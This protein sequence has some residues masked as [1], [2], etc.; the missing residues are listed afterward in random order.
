MEAPAA[1]QL[2]VDLHFQ[3]ITANFYHM[4]N[5]TQPDDDDRIVVLLDLPHLA[6][7]GRL[8]QVELVYGCS[9]PVAVGEAVSCPPTP[10]G[11]NEW[12]TGIVVALNGR[13][14]YDGPVKYVRKV[15]GNSA[16]G[17]NSSDSE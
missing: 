7:Y 8:T 9:F 5:G 16:G 4:V 15:S 17:G 13:D 3:H 6:N 1:P 10:R 12:T 14:R 2:D 11:P